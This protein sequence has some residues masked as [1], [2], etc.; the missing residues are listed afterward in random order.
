MN[1]VG[2]DWATMEFWLKQWGFGSELC[3]DEEDVF[4]GIFCKVFV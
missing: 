1:L 4:V 3:H 2:D